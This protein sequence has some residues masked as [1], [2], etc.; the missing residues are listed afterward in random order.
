MPHTPPSACS[1]SA[2]AEDAWVRG[3]ETA[4]EL[5]KRAHKRK[6]EDKNFSEKSLNLSLEK[7]EK[8]DVFIERDS[9]DTY[10][11]KRRDMVEFPK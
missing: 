7:N 1:E 6:I 10:K 5:V 8:N 3:L 9:R 11:R 2:P 4:K